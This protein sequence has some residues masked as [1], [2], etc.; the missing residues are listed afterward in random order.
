MTS[1]QTSVSNCRFY[2]QNRKYMIKCVYNH[3]I[4]VKKLIDNDRDGLLD[5]ITITPFKH[6]HQSE[7]VQSSD[8]CH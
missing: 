8:I 2:D 3:D 5:K 1:Y 7:H 4:N 6:E